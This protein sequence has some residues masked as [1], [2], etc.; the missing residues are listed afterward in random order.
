MTLR[1]FFVA[2]F[3]LAAPLGCALASA[4]S[5]AEAREP[6][7]APLPWN[8]TTYLLDIAPGNWYEPRGIGREIDAFVPSFLLRVD[9]E[10]P[11]VSR[12]TV[13]TADTDG[14]QDP[15]NATTVMDAMAAPPAV[16]MGPSVYSLFIRSDELS[17][18]SSVH[19]L[20]ITDVLPD[21]E[22]VSEVGE[23][24]AILDFRELYPFFT[25]Q[26]EP[27]PESVC[28][29]FSNQYSRPCGPC[30]NDGEPRCLTVRANSLGATPTAP[31]VPIDSVTDPACV[32]SFE[33]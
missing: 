29:L 13:G 1:R 15:C 9:G 6:S 23:L 27:T 10:A 30:P 26:L 3:R 18:R 28:A 11:D 16:A 14:Q 7:E 8:G 17:V 24:S 12:V 19:E 4:C 31:I 20:T 21:G 5:G 22:K 33:P 32:P 25:I 2:F